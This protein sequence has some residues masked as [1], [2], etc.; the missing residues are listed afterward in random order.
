M[1]DIELVNF[2]TNPAFRGKQNFAKLAL[3]DRDGVINI[4]YGYVHQKKDFVFL[5]E[6]L[7]ALHEL[8]R[9]GYGL[10][11]CTNQSGIGRGLFSL[12]QFME[13]TNYMFEYLNDESIYVGRV[14]FCP[15]CPDRA[16]FIDVKHANSENCGCRKPSPGMLKRAM[17]DFDVRAESSIMVGDSDTDVLAGMNA[18]VARSYKY[19]SMPRSE[20][21]EYDW[22]SILEKE[23]VH[24]E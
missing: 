2:L 20:F 19:S 11:I 15:H 10:A 18:G 23:R 8:Q 24:S 1:K 9:L 13:L 4:D 7:D 17:I 3:L 21:N 12:D 16:N 5:G 22:Q 6:T 14:Y